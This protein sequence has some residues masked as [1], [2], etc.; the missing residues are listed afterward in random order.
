MTIPDQLR[1]D[2][3]TLAT[4]LEA[5]FV[6]TEH[7]FL[8]W[9]ESATGPIAEAMQSAGLTPA[10]PIGQDADDRAWVSAALRGLW[11]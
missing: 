7:L 10:A 4:S 8:A 3:A 5:D 11:T 6:G 2:A 1:A 9:L